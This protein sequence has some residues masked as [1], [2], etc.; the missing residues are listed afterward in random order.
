MQQTILNFNPM[1]NCELENDL[2]WKSQNFEIS[3]LFIFYWAYLI[4]FL[5]V[6]GSARE[7][8]MNIEDEKTVYDFF[9]PISDDKILKTVQKAI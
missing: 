3:S 9:P 8:G 2:K 4:I 7:A 6:A 5:V 1:Q